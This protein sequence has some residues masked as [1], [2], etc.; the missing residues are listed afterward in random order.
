MASKRILALA[1]GDPKASRILGKD[2][3][4]KG[5]RPYITGLIKGL[6]R[7]GHQIGTDYEIDYR[8]HWYE[9]I[10]EG[11]AFREHANAPPDLIYAM[12][13][14]VM[15]AAGKHGGGNPIVF[16]NCSDHDAE[17]YVQQG[18]ATGYS[19]RR[20]QTAD[21]CFEHFLE[22]VPTLREVHL[23][24]AGGYD[25]SE[26]SVNLINACRDNRHKNVNVDVLEIK[27][28]TE[29]RTELA[30]LPERNL[31]QPAETGVLVLPVDIFFGTAPIII[32]LVQVQ[33]NLPTFWFVSDW[34]KP[35]LPSALGGFGVAQERCGKRTARSVYQILWLNPKG[36]PLPKVIDAPDHDFEWAVSGAAAAALKTP[37]ADIGGHPSVI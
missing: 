25:P 36:S 30:K 28:H 27:N 4:L 21:V 34:V 8:Q 37:L 11:H 14:T 2:P 13:T 33:K 7:L 35:E 3:D 17:P 22:T 16:P 18:R 20:S 29:L 1:V 23:L 6:T 24:H 32:D 26:L 12:S 9:H 10:V 31:Q 15:R 19:A 5:V